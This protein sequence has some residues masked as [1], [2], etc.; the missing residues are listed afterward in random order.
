MGCDG[1]DAADCKVRGIEIVWL[2]GVAKGST[3]SPEVTF[4]HPAAQSPWASYGGR[5]GFECA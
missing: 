2:S 4:Q 5:E 1:Q 3:H